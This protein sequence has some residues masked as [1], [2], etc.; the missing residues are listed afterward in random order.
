[1]KTYVHNS[2]PNDDPTWSE[3]LAHELAEDLTR[4]SSGDGTRFV[5]DPEDP[6]SVVVEGDGEHDEA[7]VDTWRA[8]AAGWMARARR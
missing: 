4:E 8:F 2:T 5:T 1:M 7:N 6:L 3:Q